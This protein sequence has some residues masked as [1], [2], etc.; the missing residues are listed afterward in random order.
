MV[1]QKDSTQMVL[2][3]PASESGGENGLL[4]A[5]VTAAALVPTI[6]KPTGALRKVP[7]AIHLGLR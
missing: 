3:L 4:P 1:V 5:K 7:V 2:P 6:D